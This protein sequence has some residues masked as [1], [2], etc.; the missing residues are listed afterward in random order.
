MS[1]DEAPARWQG[2][3]GQREEQKQGL[4]GRAVPG[5]SEEHR[6]GPILEGPETVLRSLVFPPSEMQSFGGV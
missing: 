6:G 2:H 4:G 1:N 5:G 3:G